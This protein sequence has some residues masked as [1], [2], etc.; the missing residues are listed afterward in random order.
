MGIRI[1]HSKE[2]VKETGPSGIEEFLKR[3]IKLFGSRVNSKKKE[4]FYAQL[5]TLLEAGIQLRDALVIMEQ[6]AKPKEK[7]SFLGLIEQLDAG[8]SL[9]E[10][11]ENGK[12]FGNYERL[13]IEIGEKTGHL[14]QVA[15][16]LADYYQKRNERKRQIIGALTY[17]LIILCTAVLVVVFMLRMVVPMFED[18]FRQNG[19]DLPW[20]T[21]LIVGL[22][23]FSESYGSL[24]VVIGIGG[25]FGIRFALKR[26]EVLDIWQKTL[27][28][29]PV[30]GPFVRLLHISKFT[31]T[32]SLLT[33]SKIPFLTAIQMVKDTSEF[34]PLKSALEKMELAITKGDGLYKGIIASGFFDQKMSSMV[35]VAEETNKT[36][37]VFEKLNT[38]YNADIQQKSKMLSTL[39]EPFIIIL[40][41]L[42]VGVILIAMYL[43][44]FK[45]SSVLG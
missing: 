37:Y 38:Q 42:F 28:K 4:A 19:V 22:S 16:Q 10:A 6:N 31:Q 11:F 2:V 32:L 29:L 1:E 17:P 34:L 8:Y 20:I 13:A 45:L 33:S 30:L 18:I 39:L 26:R 5:S 35:K 27:L 41:G 44:M 24:L 9:A 12:N 14:P 25:F 7:E 40:V 43:P 36:E 3:D 21:Q 23:Q 15:Q